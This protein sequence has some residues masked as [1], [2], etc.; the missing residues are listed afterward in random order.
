MSIYHPIF[1]DEKRVWD[2]PS[3]LDVPFLEGHFSGKI[4]LVLTAKGIVAHLCQHD[5]LHYLSTELIRVNNANNSEPWWNLTISLEFWE[6]YIIPYIIIPPL[7]DM[8]GEFDGDDIELAQIIMD[9]IDE[10]KS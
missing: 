10:S 3:D 6:E 8:K 2:L 4:T 7:I 1:D 9:E 5:K